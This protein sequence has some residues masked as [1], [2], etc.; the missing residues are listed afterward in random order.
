MIRYTRIVLAIPF[1]LTASLM[2]FYTCVVLFLWN[3]KE[4]T[5]SEQVTLGI[6]ISGFQ[7]VSI[8][9]GNKRKE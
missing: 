5:F 6:I 2:L 7:C 3:F 8:I 4:F 1:Y 9:A